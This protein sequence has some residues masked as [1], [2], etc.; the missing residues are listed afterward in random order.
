MT[1][2]VKLVKCF[3]LFKLV[4][5]TVGAVI[6][7]VDHEPNWVMIPTA[8]GNFVWV[9]RKIVEAKT[10]AKRGLTESDIRFIFYSRT[11]YTGYVHN[12]NG[13]TLL[14]ESVFDSSRPTRIIIHGWLNNGDSPLND[15]LRK[16]YLYNWDYNVISVDWSACSSDLNYIS[17]TSCVR[18][19]GQVVAKMLDYLHENRELSFR[20][21]Y[22]IG[23]SLG[24]H[25]AGIAGK[26]IQGGRIAT[27]VA[28][29]PALPLFSIRK[30]EN[31]VAEDDAE[32]VQVIHTN[33]GLLG[34]LEPI[35]T[36]DFYPNGGRSQPGCGWN[37]LGIC[38]H[39]R[40]WQLF[41]DS[42]L[43]ADEYLMAEPIASLDDIQS[44]GV[45]RISRAKLGGEPAAMA[46]GLYYIY[47]NAES[48]YFGL[49][50]VEVNFR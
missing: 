20:D 35:G 22:L 42:L 2:F 16:A 43:E 37:L 4:Q 29:D 1:S 18:V 45:N 27:I 7:P 15:H 23:H 32:Y 6:D 13:L 11:N 25:V 8:S 9:H 10:L 50:V 44:L 28:L 31:R 34:F 39:A 40:A 46:Y 48:P 24:S 30:P 14:S 36:A 47:T 12:L 21:V 19:V 38:S 17:A 41:L 3:L 33:G 49:P 26:L 5:S